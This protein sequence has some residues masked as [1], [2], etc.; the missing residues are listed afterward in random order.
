MWVEFVW[1]MNR[2]K[3]SLMFVTL[4]QLKQ[5]GVVCT[6]KSFHLTLQKRN[7]FSDGLI[8]VYRK[9]KSIHVQ[10]NRIVPEQSAEVTV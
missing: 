7:F 8:F 5:E 3:T 9:Q 6:K 4:H 10:N 2:M 1:Q